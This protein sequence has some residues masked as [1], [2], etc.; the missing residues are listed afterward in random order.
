MRGLATQLLDRARAAGPDAVAPI[1]Q[2]G[3]PALRARALAYDGHLSDAEL[4]ELVALMHRTMRAAPGVGLAAPQIGL[5]L[6]IAVVEDPGVDDADVAAA[7]ERVPLPFR[8]LVNPSYAPVGDERVAFYEGC[9]S[10]EGYVAV[11][12]R[13]RRVRLTCL[14]ERGAAVDEV[15]T[16]WPARIVQHET[17][18]LQGTLYLDRAETRSLAASDDLGAHWASEPVPHEAARTLGFALPPSAG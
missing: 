7:R 2:A 5:P 16:G 8:V 6:A 9:L 1:V 10:V 11:V 4:A 15:L 12:T 3:H 13:P 17:D 18:H 14:D